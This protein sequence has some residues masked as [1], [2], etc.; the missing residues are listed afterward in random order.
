MVV[1]TI[2]R[3]I[4]YCGITL[5]WFC[6]TSENKNWYLSTSSTARDC[7]R[8]LSCHFTMEPL[9]FEIFIPNK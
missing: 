9:K 8:F 5:L 1:V 6:E 2:G 3:N 7:Y 4:F